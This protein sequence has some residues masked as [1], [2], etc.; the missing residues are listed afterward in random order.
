MKRWLISAVCTTLILALGAEIKR[1]QAL[2]NE[3]HPYAG[4]PL[5]RDVFGNGPFATLI[6]GQLP[7]GSRWGA[8]A[9]RVGG[10]RVGYERPCLSI[11][12]I[13]RYG[14]YRNA[15]GCAIPTPAPNRSMALYLFIA[16]TYQT[17][18]DGPFVGETILGL[19]FQPAVRSVVLKYKDG[20][21]L[22][23]RTQLFNFKQQKKTKLPPFRYVALGV[24]DDV[25]VEQVVGYS[26]IGAELFS[27]ETGLCFW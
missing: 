19:T 21:Q 11:A 2:A 24:M 22:A 16:T 27:A 5:W 26:S 10:G 15:N 4:F 20:G 9:S 1:D 17:R 6:E 18:P 7:N 3:R 14:E 23:R 8:Y 13:T 25:C 12:Q